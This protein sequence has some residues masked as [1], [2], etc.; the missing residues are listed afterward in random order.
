[1]SSAESLS[2]VNGNPPEDDALDRAATAGP[3]PEANDDNEPGGGAEE[4]TEDSTEEAGR[5][6]VLGLHLRG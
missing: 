4:H 5:A 1:M 6:S 3:L 2:A